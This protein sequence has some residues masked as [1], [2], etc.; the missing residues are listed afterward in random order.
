M[1]A[2]ELGRGP[3]RE[4]PHRIDVVILGRHRPRVHHAHVA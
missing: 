3:R 2:L 1:A 4:D